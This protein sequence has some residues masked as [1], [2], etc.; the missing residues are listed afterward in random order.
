MGTQ[1][2]LKMRTLQTLSL[3]YNVYQGTNL[4]GIF[5]GGERHG[6]NN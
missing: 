1:I 5:F 2:F 3:H 4:M 6:A